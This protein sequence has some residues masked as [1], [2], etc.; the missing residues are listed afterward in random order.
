MADDSNSPVKDKNY[1]LI[2]VLQLSLHHV[3]MLDQYVQDARSQGD[4]ELANWLQRIQEN[5]K[6]AG[7][8]GKEML[9]K[10]LQRENG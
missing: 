4:E 3:W 9:L 6:T 7:Q 8:Q 10:R 2:N 1:N 5:N